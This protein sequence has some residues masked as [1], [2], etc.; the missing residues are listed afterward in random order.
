VLEEATHDGR[1]FADLS[2]DVWDAELAWVAAE[3]NKPEASAVIRSAAGALALAV[4]C[5]KAKET[6][7][8]TA[9]A[10]PLARQLAADSQA[11]ALAR[12]A[13]LLEDPKTAESR[14]TRSSRPWNSGRCARWAVFSSGY[15]S[16]K[17][18]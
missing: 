7:M 15:S 4:Y 14:P 2:L 13:Q 18:W 6:A 8:A 11:A 12:A 9:M 3:A 1:R 10:A 5:L 17:R 16:Q